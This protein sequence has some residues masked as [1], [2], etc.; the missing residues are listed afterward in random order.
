MKKQ[1]LFILVTLVMNV[2]SQSARAISLGTVCGFKEGQLTKFSTHL[3]IKTDQ[4]FGTY[5]SG[6]DIIKN[7]A[8]LDGW[9]PVWCYGQPLSSSEEVLKDGYFKFKV[10]GVK[11]SSGLLLTNESGDTIPIKICMGKK[12]SGLEEYCAEGIGGDEITIPMNSPESVEK[13]NQAVLPVKDSWKNPSTDLPFYKFNWRIASHVEIPATTNPSPGIYSGLVQLGM[14]VHFRGSLYKDWV[15]G[16]VE[17]STT[18]STTYRVFIHKD[19]EFQTPDSINFGTANFVGQLAIAR[20][21]LTVLCTKNTPYIIKMSGKNDHGGNHD[22]HYMINKNGESIPYQLYKSDG[23]TLWNYSN[24]KKYNGTGTTDSIDILARV[25]SGASEV[26]AG[27]YSD[28][29]T[30]ELTY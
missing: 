25:I 9:Q 29:I 2:W 18:F 4:N 13:F 23:T 26:T 8:Q 11:D 30:A 15:D 6:L 5:S 1:F 7:G 27:K 3:G 21:K 12:G 17:G 20:G 19:C 10:N 16:P 14:S 28:T 22:T 24:P